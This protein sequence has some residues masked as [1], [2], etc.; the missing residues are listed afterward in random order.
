M[1]SKFE[2]KKMK[3][4][5]T[6][7]EKKRFTQIGIYTR[8]YMNYKVKENDLPKKYLDYMRLVCKHNVC[9]SNNKN[10]SNE[11]HD[12]LPTMEQIFDF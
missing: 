6:N 11:L 10:I 4:T 5:R 7:T 9:F 3:K 12:T 8:E 1:T 2:I